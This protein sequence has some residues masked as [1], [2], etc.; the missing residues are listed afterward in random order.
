[1]IGAPGQPI[2]N[3][4]FQFLVSNPREQVLQIEVNDCLGFADMAIG[5]G[6]V[7]HLSFYPI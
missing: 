7:N 5:I 2:W 4:D 3:Q 1:V 6:E